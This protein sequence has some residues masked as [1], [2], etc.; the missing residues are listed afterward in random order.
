MDRVRS[1]MR[2]PQEFIDTVTNLRNAI[3]DLH[4]ELLETAV[5]NEK[6]VSFV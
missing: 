1:K 4:Y 2:G 5:S 3:T 6:V